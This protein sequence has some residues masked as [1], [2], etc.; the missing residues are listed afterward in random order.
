MYL[1]LKKLKIK[2]LKLT[3][4]KSAEEREDII[5]EFRNDH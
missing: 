2:Y 5:K 3:N 1:K 4:D